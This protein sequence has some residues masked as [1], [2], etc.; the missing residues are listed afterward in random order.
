MTKIKRSFII[1]LSI[2]PAFSSCKNGNQDNRS[3]SGIYPHLS[4]YN[5]EG[6]CGT[7]AVVP[8]A[9]RLWVVT[10]GPHLP[11]GSSDKLYEIT[12]DLRQITR[13]ESIGGTHANRMIHEESGQL[14]IGP[15]V[16]DRNRNIR[17][18]PYGKM[19]G[20]LTGNA[21]HLTD[22]AEKIYYATMEEGFYE[23]DVNSLEV[24]TLYEDSNLTVK[25][26]GDVSSNL[27][28]ALLAGDHGKGFYSGQGVAVYSNNGEY[29]EE[30][31]KNP[32]IESGS[33][34]EWDGTIWKLIRRNQFVEVTGP[35]GLYGNK[36]PESDPLWATG[37]DNKS[38][39]LGVRDAGKWSFYRLPKA[40]HT[41][42]GA[43]GWNTEWP[44]IRD[45][46]EPGDPEYLMTMHGMFWRF[47]G[48]FSSS[49]SAGIRPRS[50]YLKVIGD[51]TRWN[52]TSLVFGCDDSAQKEFLNK[53][54][55]KGNIEGPGQSNSNLWFTTTSQPDNLGPVNAGGAVW[56]NEKIAEG[57]CSE[58]FL[59]AG[60]PIRMCW[61]R[62]DGNYDNEFIFEIDRSGNG[63]WEFLKSVRVA[64]NNSIHIGFEPQSPGEWIRVKSKNAV[65]ATVY[66]SYAGKEK[67]GSSPDEIFEGLSSADERNSTGGLLYGLGN[68]RRALGILAGRFDGNR[69]IEEGYYEL[70]GRMALTRKENDTTADFIRYRFAI[71]GEAVRFDEASAIIDDDMGRRWRLPVKNR[72]FEDL[73]GASA[74]RL[75]REVATERD[76]FNCGGTFYEL[77]ANN[78]D[79]FAKIRPVASHNFRI[80]DYA[81]YRGM[82]IMT[83]IDPE[84]AKTNSHVIISD[85]GKVAVWA[86][87]IDDLWKMGKPSGEGGPWKN[88]EVC[89]GTPSDPYLIGFFDKRSLEINHD[90]RDN[91]RFTIE[92]DPSGNGTWMKYTEVSVNEGEVFRHTFPESFQARW[93]RFIPDRNC[94]ATAWLKYE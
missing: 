70:D 68:N 88:S 59:F 8:W 32:N 78:A 46:G 63:T 64:R 69:F 79:G 73:S 18:I 75:C 82:L 41:Y 60:W 49:N 30:A 94:K 23:V 52:D 14:F 39:I 11:F 72:A 51:F 29:G 44:R 87:V 84:R 85:D 27:K 54:K 2:L 53:R 90:L 26:S 15:Y 1:L 4:Y 19:P 22:P 76:L 3:F 45:V 35:G 12:P 48:T 62:N 24:K 38:L 42:D 92:A 66:F 56:L 10:Y 17:V 34:S 86:G 25:K 81:S 58:P 33:L 57:E 67:R 47:P 77:P 5:N 61:I 74:L 21:R 9:G 7:G 83:G 43:H 91:V 37:W 89:A 31:I 16:I 71:P 50:A 13:K 28:N 40:S 80:H 55:E 20:R 36:N 65:I 93:I 6:E